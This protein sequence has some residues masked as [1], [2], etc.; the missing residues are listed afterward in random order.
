MNLCAACIALEFGG[1]SHSLSTCSFPG[2]QVA[3]VI[4][5]GFGPLFCLVMPSEVLLH[6][7]SGLLPNF[8]LILQD[9]QLFLNSIFGLVGGSL[10][11]DSLYRVQWVENS[12]SLTDVRLGL[13]L[14]ISIVVFMT[15]CAAGTS[16][17]VLVFGVSPYSLDSS[18]C[19]PG[20]QVA[21]V[22]VLGVVFIAFFRVMEVL[23]QLNLGLGLLSS[24]HF[25]DRL[26]YST[27]ESSFT[28][29]DGKFILNSIFG[30]VGGALHLDSLQLVQ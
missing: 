25:S 1:S 16:D 4:A 29:N 9:S 24:F 12:D 14:M 3:L 20:L 30:L 28:P 26:T 21:L 17:I 5:F 23:D 6:L 27:S 18:Y 13:M 15:L 10:H 19:F 7:E 8:T 11:L 2:M 22:M